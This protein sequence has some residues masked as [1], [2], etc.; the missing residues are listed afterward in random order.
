MVIYWS[1]FSMSAKGM[2]AWMPLKEIFVLQMVGGFSGY[3]ALSVGPCTQGQRNC[4]SHR[5]KEARQ[6]VRRAGCHGHPWPV[7]EWR[8][9]VIKDP[10]QRERSQISQHFARH[11]NFTLT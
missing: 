5:K 6:R 3:V 4:H 11:I 10:S 8:G 2:S 1:L 9:T 7:V